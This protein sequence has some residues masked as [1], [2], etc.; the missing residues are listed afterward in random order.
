MKLRLSNDTILFSSSTKDL[1]LMIDS[2]LQFREQ[3]TLFLMR[4]YA[5]LK[6]VYA[7]RFCLSRNTKSMLYDSLKLSSFNFAEHVYGPFLGSVDIRRVQKA[8]NSCLRLMFGERRSQR[9]SNP[10]ITGTWMA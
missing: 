9:V 5:L 4:A 3:I 7:H 6:L 8:K 10:H 2:K 1:G